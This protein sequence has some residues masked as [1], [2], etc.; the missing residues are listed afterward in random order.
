MGSPAPKPN[1]NPNPNPAPDQEYGKEFYLRKQIAE[2][3]QELTGGPRVFCRIRAPL[4][5]EADGA[6]AS[7]QA[8]GARGGTQLRQASAN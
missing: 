4:P 8:E 2:Q 1:P 3:V 7:C 5:D 6:W